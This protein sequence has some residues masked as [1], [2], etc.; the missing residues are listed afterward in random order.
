LPLTGNSVATVT[1]PVQPAEWALL[2]V[3]LVPQ[4]AA[5]RASSAST[6]VN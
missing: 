3:L 4:P 5:P 2:D 6:V 1:V